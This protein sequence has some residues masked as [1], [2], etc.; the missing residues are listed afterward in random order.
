LVGIACS[1][2]LAYRSLMGIVAAPADALLFLGQCRG[3]SDLLI[4]EREALL[5]VATWRLLE[6]REVL[7]RQNESASVVFL[8]HHG[9]LRSIARDGFGMRVLGEHR[10]GSIIGEVGVLA[11]APRTADVVAI[12]ET[13]V[14]Q[15]DAETFM[16]V[17]RS[18]SNIALSVARVLS[19]RLSRPTMP[20]IKN[21]FAAIVALDD[22]RH[23]PSFRK[24]IASIAKGANAEVLWLQDHDTLDFERLDDDVRYLLVQQQWSETT[25]ALCRQVDEIIVITSSAAKPDL[26]RLRELDTLVTGVEGPTCRMVIAHPSRP[27]WRNVRC[28]NGRTHVRRHICVHSV[29]RGRSARWRP[30]RRFASP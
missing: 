27:T 6:G 12:R 28:R 25:L 16:N 18:H 20:A 15:I 9:A 24:L 3:F 13:L 21:H 1:E 30:R 8:V 17:L 2:G 29:W 22:V 7:L 19:E 4:E 26:V 23:D 14:A 11:D 5:R 10:R